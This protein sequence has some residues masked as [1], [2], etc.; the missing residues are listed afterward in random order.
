MTAWTPAARKRY[1]YHQDANY[2]VTLLTGESGGVVERYDYSAYGEPGVFGGAISGGLGE[3]R[4][5]LTVSSVGNPLMHQGLFRDGESGSYQNRYRQYGSGVG[6]FLQH[7]RPDFVD[8]PSALQYQRSAPLTG[9][10]SSGTQRNPF[11][12]FHPRPCPRNGEDPTNP[13]DPFIFCSL[14]FGLPPPG[15][16][17]EY[18][19]QGYCVSVGSPIAP[20]PTSAP[21]PTVPPPPAPTTPVPPAAPAAKYP[22]EREPD[23]NAPPDNVDISDCQHECAVKY[24]PTSGGKPGVGPAPKAVLDFARCARA[25]Q[26]PPLGPP[27]NCF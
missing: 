20:Q 27:C 17:Y 11:A 25:V 21:A 7:D 10:D 4:A 8:G 6:R 13:I 18:D 14:L 19:S 24:G 12:G 5:A 23:Q 26:T 9:V 3:S 22:W 1:F 2:R 16:H 15:V